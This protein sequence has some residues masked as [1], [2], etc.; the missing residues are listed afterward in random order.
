[1]GKL[2]GVADAFRR[3]SPWAVEHLFDFRESIQR[4]QHSGGYVAFVVAC[5]ASGFKMVERDG[6]ATAR[7]PPRPPPLCAT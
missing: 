6:E 4:S 5:N 1:M 7:T 3:A 2:V